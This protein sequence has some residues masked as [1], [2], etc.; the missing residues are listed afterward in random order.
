[1]KKISILILLFVLLS[2][3][4]IGQ[5]KFTKQ[6]ILSKVNTFLD[7]YSELSNFGT[8]FVK[9]PT[10][11]TQKFT[12]QF[13]DVDAK[14]VCNDLPQLIKKERKITP[15]EYC[16]ILYSEFPNGVIAEIKYDT[17]EASPL[18]GNKWIIEA[19]VT[20]SF[21][22]P[23]KISDDNI[24][25]N[26]LIKITFDSEFKITEITSIDDIDIDGV[27]DNVDVCPDEYGFQKFNGCPDSDFDG[28]P[29]ITDR[30]PNS[31]EGE[32]V[33]KY[34][35]YKYFYEDVG[36][37][38]IDFSP[39]MILTSSVTSP[40]SNISNKPNSNQNSEFNIGYKT[41]LN[42]VKALF[43]NYKD[44]IVA[45][46]VGAG[47]FQHNFTLYNNA[48]DTLS[49]KISYEKYKIGY[50]P[51]TLGLRDYGFKKR[52]YYGAGIYALFLINSKNYKYNSNKEASSDPLSI[53]FFE[54]EK[55]G[56]YAECG[57][58]F[59][60]KGATYANI[61]LEYIFLKN[62]QSKTDNN[63]VNLISKVQDLK[64][65]LL[66]LRASIMFDLSDNK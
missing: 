5:E 35:C 11:Y 8:E 12:S 38:E 45:L 17:V 46:K 66:S 4:S 41:S 52:Y 21:Y 60:I 40:G 13:L 64:Q 9:S 2:I 29:D 55:I 62:I 34:G 10:R 27:V 23:Y 57:Y 31:P 18:S 15:R 37:M 54:S 1:M 49:S 65:N 63:N 30:C 26:L 20:K 16:D 47:Y 39:T 19:N 6:E 48:T 58:V 59:H 44:N 24:I 53:S 22:G 25:H 56:L 43:G 61:G 32:L 7:T 3:H 14:T 36:F 28:I 42:L 50:I 33:N 51:F